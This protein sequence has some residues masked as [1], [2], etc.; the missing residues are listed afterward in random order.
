MRSRIAERLSEN[1]SRWSTGA[2]SRG[3]YAEKR[4]TVRN[5]SSCD[6]SLRS[7][8]AVIRTAPAECRHSLLCVW[9]NYLFGTVPVMNRRLA[10]SAGNGGLEY[11]FFRADRS[12]SIP[13]RRET[14]TPATVPRW[15]GFYFGAPS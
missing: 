1:G 5:N 4:P 12:V 8:L 3:H 13:E 9:G 2:S 6:L 14:L 10:T 7:A 11:R 15:N